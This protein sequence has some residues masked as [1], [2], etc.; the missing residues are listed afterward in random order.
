[1]TM[2]ALKTPKDVGKIICSRRKELGLKQQDAAGLLGVGVRFLSE[3]ERGK[4]TIALGKA[5]MVLDGLGIKL[6]AEIAR[7]KGD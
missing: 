1:M 6:S 5:L 2:T 3:L 7:G 4:D